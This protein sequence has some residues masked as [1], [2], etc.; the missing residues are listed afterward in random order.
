MGPFPITPG[1]FSA[2]QYSSSRRPSAELNGPQRMFGHHQ[3]SGRTVFSYVIFTPFFEHSDTSV[4][5]VTK[6]GNWCRNKLKSAPCKGLLVKRRTLKP[7]PQP[8]LRMDP[9]HTT[10]AGLS[11]APQIPTS[12]NFDLLNCFSNYP[13]TQRCEF[14]K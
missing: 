3:S 10:L 6:A 12:M 2:F 9:F 14:N 7:D 11:V 8:G 4:Q 13:H 5:R 1:W